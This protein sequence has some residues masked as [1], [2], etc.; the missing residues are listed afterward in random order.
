MKKTLALVLGLILMASFALPAQAF[1]RKDMDL[2]KG[3]VVAYNAAKKML[4]VLSDAGDGK[5][6]C[7]ISSAQISTSTAVGSQ[8]VVVYKKAGNVATLVKPVPKR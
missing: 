1:M 4:T 5:I 2:V 7:D 6:V 3:K 8:V